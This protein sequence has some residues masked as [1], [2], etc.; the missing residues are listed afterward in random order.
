MPFKGRKFRL[1]EGD[2]LFKMMSLPESSIDT[3]ITDPP[4]GL[5]FMGKNWDHGIPSVPF[6]SEALRVAKPGAMLLAF[7]GTRTFHRLTCAIEDAGWEIRDCMM[8]LYGSG[9]PK[10]HDI[11]K[12]IDKAAKATREVVSSGK[13]IKRMIPGADQDRTGS[14]IKDNGRE[15]TPTITAASTDAAKLWNGWGSALK[16][17]WE[18]IIVAMK[19]LDGTFAENAQMHGVGGFNINGSRI[20]C[21]GGS[22]AASRRVSSRNTG[23]APMQIRTLG[24]ELASEANNLGKIGRRGSAEVY[25]AERPEEQLGR[26]P[27]NVLLD[28]IA[29]EMLDEQSGLLTSGKPGVRRRAHETNAMSERLNRTGKLEAGLGDSEGASRFFYCAKTSRSERGGDNNHPTVKPV[30]LMRYLCKLTK[31]PTGGIVLD[32]FMGSGSTGIAALKEGRT[33]IGIEK[34]PAYFRIAADRILDAEGM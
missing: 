21:D 20:Q 7:G 29:A 10:S 31:T 26:W 1:I 4:Y 34:D 25:Q 30:R 16:P 5:K 33:F 24:V 6:W 3:I 27:A 32:P 19:P 14:W 9:F 12:G 15:F 28:E 13:A 23:N 18:P 8:W 11:S 2:C 22:P 17:A